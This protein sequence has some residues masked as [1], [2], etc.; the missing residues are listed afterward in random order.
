MTKTYYAVQGIE[1]IPC[2]VIAKKDRT[3]GRKFA[4][5][6]RRDFRRFASAFPDRGEAEQEV[7][8]NSFARQSNL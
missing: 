8:R 5:D 4:A 1:I 7:L 2:H 6:S 3:D